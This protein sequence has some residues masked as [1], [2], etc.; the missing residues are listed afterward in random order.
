MQYPL[1]SAEH[2]P[3]RTCTVTYTT[4]TASTETAE[5]SG[6]KLESSD[7]SEVEAASL[8]LSLSTGDN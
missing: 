4:S 3:H 5:C 6:T 7:P 2:D 1:V 8:L